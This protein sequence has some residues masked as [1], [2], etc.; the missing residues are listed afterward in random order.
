MKVEAKF[1]LTRISRENCLSPIS[2]YSLK[3]QKNE[4]KH[5][6]LAMLFIKCLL[7]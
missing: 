2:L 5:V 6:S 7:F 4:D 3:V 1:C